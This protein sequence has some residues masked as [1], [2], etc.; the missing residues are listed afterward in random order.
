MAPILTVTM[1]PALDVTAQVSHMAPREKLRCK[2]PTYEPG[3]GGINVSRVVRE[4]GGETLCFAVLGGHTGQKLRTLLEAADLRPE[5]FEIG[6]LSRESIMIYDQAGETQYRFIMPGPQLSEQECAGA[7]ERIEALVPKVRYVVAS[8]SLPPGVPASFYADLTK[9]VRAAG[10]EIVLDTSGPALK[11][12]AQAPVSVLK[13]DEE[14]MKE[15][16]PDSLA[17]EENEEKLA[18][19]L[20][21]STGADVIVVTLG[22]RGALVATPEG[23]ERLPSA[24]VRPVSTVGAGDSFVAAMTKALC[25]GHDVHTATRYGSAAGAAAVITPGSELARRAD[26]ERLFAEL[27]GA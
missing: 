24:K 8:G 9:R 5:V 20:L 3:G 13:L 27:K 4:M 19:E 2:D 26:I 22:A 21:G 23:V 6:E 25:D 7:L 15:V 12:A 11:A 18:L 10:G 14:E 1:N 17:S 16:A